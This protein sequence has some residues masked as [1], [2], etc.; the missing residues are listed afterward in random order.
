MIQVVHPGSGL[1][2]HPGTRIQGS[3]KNRIPDP[4][5]G[6]LCF[7]YN[8]PQFLK[9]R[10]RLLIVVRPLILTVFRISIGISVDLQ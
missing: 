10:H 5:H 3:K 8:L 2:T 4:Q 9:Y 6:F 7:K 1:C